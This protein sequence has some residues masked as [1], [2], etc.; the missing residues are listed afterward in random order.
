M[1]GVPDSVRSWRWEPDGIHFTPDVRSSRSDG[2]GSQPS[3]AHALATLALLSDA[4]AHHDIQSRL[5]HPGMI[6]ETCPVRLALGRLHRLL[7]MLADAPRSTEAYRAARIVK[8]IDEPPRLYM[9]VNLRLSKVSSMHR[10]ARRRSRRQ[11]TRC[12]KLPGLALSDNAGVQPSML[13]SRRSMALAGA[14]G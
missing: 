10:R 4:E 3:A 5:A 12:V 14:G 1:H 2:V 9:V 8:G 13:L 7:L 11:C 6:T